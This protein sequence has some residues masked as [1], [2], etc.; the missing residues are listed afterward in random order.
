[1]KL[2]RPPPFIMVIFWTLSPKMFSI[3]N[4]ELALGLSGPHDAGFKPDEPLNCTVWLPVVTENGPPSGDT[5]HRIET[6]VP[7]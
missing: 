3:T 7:A 4:A 1:M 6:L 5:T 2:S